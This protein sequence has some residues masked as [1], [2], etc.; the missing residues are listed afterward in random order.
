MVNSKESI[1]IREK[2]NR[3]YRRYVVTPQVMERYEKSYHYELYDR[4]VLKFAMD[5]I[6]NDSDCF[7]LYAIAQMGCADLDTVRSF[8]SAMSKRN[9]QLSISSMDDSSRD[10]V[11]KRISS[12]HNNGFL[13]RYSYQ[14]DSPTS[15]REGAYL[16]MDTHSLYTIDKM[17]QMFMNEHFSKRVAVRDWLV[18]KNI[19]ELVSMG[20][21]SFVG[22]S[23]AN[24]SDAFVEY[25]KGVFKSRTI[26]TCYLSLEIKFLKDNQPYYIGVVPAYMHH[27]TNFQS[28]EDF[29][30]ACIYKLNLIKN[31]LD[32]RD[33]RG[34]ESRIVVS[35][36][37]NGD[38]MEFS[39]CVSRYFNT[40][41]NYLDRIY[42]TGEG[43]IRG[44]E[45]IKE[46][47]LRLNLDDDGLIGFE[48]AEPEFI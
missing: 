22:A 35:V 34:D 20:S 46:A 29:E 24:S 28:E 26:G 45:N 6:G 5:N 43:A 18:A 8:L 38:L 16:S 15:V 17:S 30:D 39:R 1:I 31:Y 41:S 2:L 14:V 11:R 36:E 40:I 37:N 48:E 33:A 25:K 32:F 44:T 3:P 42:L 47:F 4:R 12:L 21:A 7:I 27:Y 9:K 19:G 13:F 23:I 10:Y